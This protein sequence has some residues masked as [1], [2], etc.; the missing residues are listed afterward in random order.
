MES[1]NAASPAASTGAIKDQISRCHAIRPLPSCLWKA[2]GRVLPSL[3]FSTP[4]RTREIDN[5]GK[6]EKTKSHF[7]RGRIWLNRLVPVKMRLMAA[8]AQ[9]SPASQIPRMSGKAKNQNSSEKLPCFCG[10]LNLEAYGGQLIRAAAKAE[11]TVTQSTASS[12]TGRYQLVRCCPANGKAY[13]AI[14]RNSGK[15]SRQITAG[16]N[17]SQFKIMLRPTIAPNVRVSKVKP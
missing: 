17:V 14:Q 6:S 15:Q 16:T 4:S 5:G 8:H 1:N 11:A 13:D 3:P 12:I 9:T 7:A 10:F 2:V